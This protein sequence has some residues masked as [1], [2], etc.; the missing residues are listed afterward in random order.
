[1]A[2]A[3]AV[4]EAVGVSEVVVEKE[5]VAVAV[6]ESVELISSTTETVDKKA[7][8]HDPKQGTQEALL[9]TY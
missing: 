4:E 6:E 3:V 1:M 8:V 5:A 9:V 7:G 2:V